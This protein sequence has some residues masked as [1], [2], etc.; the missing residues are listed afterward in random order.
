MLSNFK[1]YVFTQFI[2][3]SCYYIASTITPFKPIEMPLIAIDYFFKPHYSAF[4]IYMSFF[5]LL[6]AGITFCSKEDSITCCKIV[7][8]NSLFATIFFVFLPTRITYNDYYPYIMD[9]TLTYDM[10]QLIKKYDNT[11]NC[12]PSLHIANSIIATIYLNKNKSSIFKVFSTIWLLL[13]CWS[14]LSTKQHNFY[15]LTAGTILAFVSLYI[16]TN[17]KMLSEGGRKITKNIKS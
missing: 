13:V 4:W 5:F 3:G 8:L 15:D 12:F 1:H 10:V 17:W 14:V 16:V 7:L 2:V 9:G 6:I 11:S